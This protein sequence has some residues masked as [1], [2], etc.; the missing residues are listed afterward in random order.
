VACVAL[1]AA[2]TFGH[3]G[4]TL[5]TSLGGKLITGTYDDD[6]NTAA[7]PHSV[8]LGEVVPTGGPGAP[9]EAEAPGSPGFR[10][11][12]QTFLDNIA[13]MDPAGV[14]TALPGSTNLEF[15]FL[16]MS[17]GPN[18]RNLF[19][20][21]GVGSVNF[22]PVASDYELSLIKFGGGGFTETIT[23]SD[24]SVITG[25]N[26]QTTTSAGAVHTHLFAQLDINDAG[27][28]DPAQGFYLFSLQ[29]RMTGLDTSDPAFYIF[30]AYDPATLTGP[31]LEEF[32][33]AHEL[34]EVWVEANLVPEPST[35]IMAAMALAGLI[36]F[37]RRKR[38]C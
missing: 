12:S 25:N 32:E 7:A 18:T 24:A 14:Y 15:D 1:T 4:D 34:A 20:W 13:S 9:Y 11:A 27:T 28:D 23:G 2:T 36:G 29:F 33:E 6:N 38:A 30:G 17:I 16:P 37:R 26:I 5:V 21:D 10:A 3:E 31:A 22:T 19:F 35:A 8:F